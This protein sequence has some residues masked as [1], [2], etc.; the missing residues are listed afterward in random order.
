LKVLDLFAGLG[1][2]SE[3]FRDRGHEVFTVDIDPKFD[4]D[5]YKDI[6][7]L[8]ADDIP[9][10]PDVILASP[11]CEKFSVMTIGRN[12]NKDN[13]PK[14]QEA[15]DALA[16][17]QR[18]L[19]FIELMQPWY[20]IMENP[21]GKLRALE[22]M[23]PYERRTVTYCKLG[24]PYMKPTDLWG[25][26]PPSLELP[27]TCR[28]GDPC[29]LR[30]PRGSTTGVQGRTKHEPVI[31][32]PDRWDKPRGTDKF[33]GGMIEEMARFPSW[34]PE[35]KK[36]SAERAKIPYKLSELVC[37]ATERDLNG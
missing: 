17:V 37:L 22:I 19:E 7:Y 1:G 8:M 21:R 5:L 28:N 16:L 9:W 3:A 4:V 20:W 6:F 27:P 33:R 14:R 25:G 24:L 29:H 10:R 30:A 18:T 15:A 23:S 2:W 35:R 11:P 26:F 34:S 32:N 12:W 31:E 36:L 13:T